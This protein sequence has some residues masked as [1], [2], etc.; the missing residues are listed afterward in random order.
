MNGI[1]NPLLTCLSVVV[2]FLA[3]FTALE[4][5]ATLSTVTS[6]RWRHVWLAAS[7]CAMG[8]G[9]W[10]MHFIGM[11]ALTL[12]IAVGYDIDVTAVSLVLAVLAVLAALVAFATVSRG[13]LSARRLLA[14]GTAMG[15]GVAAMHYTGMIAM[16]MTPSIDYDHA[17]VALSIAIAIGASIAALWL[18]FHLR[19]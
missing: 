9:I 16:R 12:P 18:A 5:S 1:Y 8:I 2:A 14:A 19:Y 17:R 11:I 3:S 7:A 13:C 15:L 4:G 6:S 10:S